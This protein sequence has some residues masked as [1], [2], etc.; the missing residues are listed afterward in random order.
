MNVK[1]TV[2]LAAAVLVLAG[3][4]STAAAKDCTAAGVSC[5][6]A[7]TAG[8]NRPV[9]TQA[10]P[11]TD[12]AASPTSTAEAPAAFGETRTYSDGLTVTVSKGA[13]FTPS[14]SAAG[15]TGFKSF[16]KFTVTVVNG[17]G[18]VFDVSLFQASV[19]SANVEGSQVYDFGSTDGLSGAPSTK[20]LAG[21]EAKFVIGFGVT[22]PADVVFQATPDFQHNA[23][24]FN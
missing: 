16:L 10:A 15:T 21:R 1:L 2:A 22:N 8:T 6:Q 23:V 3:C 19:Q 18:A 13:A 20:L 7:A 12:P 17:T 11:T 5:T 24:M 4:S 9:D 14:D